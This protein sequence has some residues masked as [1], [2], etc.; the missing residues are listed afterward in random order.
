CFS[1]TT[2][3]WI[4]ADHDQRWDANAGALINDR[5]NGWFSASV[6]YGS[7]LT[8]A[9]SDVS[10][11]FL[12]PYCPPDPATGVGS[13]ACKV[14]PHVTI[15]VE[16]GIAVGRKMGSLALRVRNVF[17]DRYFVT[18]ANAQG[19][20]VAR[21]RSVE[22]NYRLERQPPRRAGAASPAGRRGAGSRGR[23]GGRL[24]R[25]ARGARRCP[26]P[27]PIRRTDRGAG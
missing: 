13:S 27:A 15:D 20:H 25:R 9:A 2:P 7:G 14:P 26:G 22:V 12:N 10:A 5:H 21:P 1:G 4:P 11:G 16:K 23:R 17:N 24:P 3:D 8:T 19:N 18:F 6:E